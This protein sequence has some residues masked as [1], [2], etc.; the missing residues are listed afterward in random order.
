MTSGG[1]GNAT[2]TLPLYMY[3]AMTRAR[4]YGMTM[5]VGFATMLFGIVLM[6]IVFLAS[7]MAERRWQ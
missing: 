5:T 1:P 2:L 4:Q 3:N 7:K 6:L